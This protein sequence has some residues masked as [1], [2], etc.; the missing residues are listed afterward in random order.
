MPRVFFSLLSLVN[1][2]SLWNESCL[3]TVEGFMLR[4]WCRL[5]K[6]AAAALMHNVH[7][8]ELRLGNLDKGRQ[9]AQQNVTGN[10]NDKRS[11]PFR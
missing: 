10:H 4:T 3:D 5:M 11:G 8:I 6:V 9:L 2:T 1:I 7:V